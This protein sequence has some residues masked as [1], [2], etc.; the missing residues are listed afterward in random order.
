MEELAAVHERNRLARELHDSVSQTLF[1]MTLT[2]EAARLLL[3][4]DPSRVAAQP[5]RLQTLAR[6]ALAEMRSLILQRPSRPP[7]LLAA[8]LFIAVAGFGVAQVIPVAE[9]YRLFGTVTFLPTFFPA[10]ILLFGA[11]IL[12]YRNDWLTQMPG[13]LLRVW[14]PISLAVVLAMPPMPSWAARQTGACT[15]S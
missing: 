10:Y 8:A 5:D 1:S 9:S 15:S 4:R 14:A 7:A 12:G 6:D 13:R 3:D 11:G 2:A